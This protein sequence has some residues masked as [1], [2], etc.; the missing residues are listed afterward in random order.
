MNNSVPQMT[1]VVDGEVIRARCSACQRIFDPDPEK[2]TGARQES[3]LQKLFGEHVREAHNR[4][5]LRLFRR[6]T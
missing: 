2:G 5:P 3:H 1:I 4:K 6:S